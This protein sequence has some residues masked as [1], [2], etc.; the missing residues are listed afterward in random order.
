MQLIG[1]N[2]TVECA[3]G[4]TRKNVK[5]WLDESGRVHYEAEDGQM[6]CD[7][8]A[9]TNRAGGISY[10]PPGVADFIFYQQRSQ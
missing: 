6:L 3:D 8:C 5:I 7:D 9:V 2:Y 10:L 1:D 4:V